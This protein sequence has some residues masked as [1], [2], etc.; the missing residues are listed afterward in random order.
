MCEQF[1][2]SKMRAAERSCARD[3]LIID[4]SPTEAGRGRL[5]CIHPKVIATASGYCQTTEE[6]CVMGHCFPKD[7]PGRARFARQ[8]R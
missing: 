6:G 2:S 3:D 5:L 7:H 4:I 8:S 1:L